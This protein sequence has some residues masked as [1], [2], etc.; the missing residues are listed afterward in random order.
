MKPVRLYNIWLRLLRPVLHIGIIVS[1][2]YLLY[3]LRHVTDLIPGVQLPVPVINY[4]ETM[5]Y[6][7]ISAFLFVAI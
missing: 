5:V 4:Q 6:A 2:F 3:K 7:F 1:I